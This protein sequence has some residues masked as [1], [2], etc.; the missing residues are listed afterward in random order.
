VLHTLKK[1][2][3]YLNTGA[4][5]VWGISKSSNKSMNPCCDRQNAI[6]LPRLLT[7][8]VFYS[9]NI[10]TLEHKCAVEMAP[11]IAC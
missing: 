7:G 1:K 3:L 2:N 11:A 8:S 6:Q 5:S 4:S 10:V 9:M